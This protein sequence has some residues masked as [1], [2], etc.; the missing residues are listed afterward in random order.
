MSGFDVVSVRVPFEIVRRGG[1]KV[2][3]VPERAVTAPANLSEPEIDA[4]LLKAVVRAWRWRRGIEEGRWASLSD[5]AE[6]AGVTVSFVCRML[7]LTTLAPDLLQSVLDGQAT[8]RLSLTR[9]SGSLSPL[10]EE[11][12]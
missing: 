10:W 5:I 11:Q 6:R 7:A 2:I 3:V 1:R 4:V 12:R 9:I 8:P